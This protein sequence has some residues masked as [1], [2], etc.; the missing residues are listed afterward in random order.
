MSTS[1]P[2][3]RSSRRPPEPRPQPRSSS[4]PG[5]SSTPRRLRQAAGPGHSPASRAVPRLRPGEKEGRASQESPAHT[6]AT[7]ANRRPL[8]QAMDSPAGCAPA[9]QEERLAGGANQ[10]LPECASRGKRT[11]LER[12]ARGHGSRQDLK[13][14]R[15]GVRPMARHK[16][17]PGA[18]SP[19]DQGE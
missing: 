9:N 7:G 10:K 1:P 5:P 11:A 14:D 18:G 3:P 13:P 16:G 12:G 19:R 15:Q 4:L 2:L 8:R 6:S 17:R